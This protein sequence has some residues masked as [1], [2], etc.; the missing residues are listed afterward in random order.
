MR[1]FWAFI[2]ILATVMLFLLPITPAVYDFKTDVRQ[3]SFTTPTAVGATTAN[4]VLI[5]ELYDD[6]VMTISLAS[7]LATDVPAVVSYNATNRALLVSGL[8]DNTTR[9]LVVDYDVDSLNASPAIA[10]FIDYIPW[11]VLLMVILL[12]AAGIAGMFIRR[13]F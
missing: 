2:I 5:K 11:F 8:T 7:D 9:G 13:L 3:D 4:V 12:P 10:T 6:D 1:V